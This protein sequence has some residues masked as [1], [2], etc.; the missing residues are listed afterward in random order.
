V[1]SDRGQ[2]LGTRE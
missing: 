1:D 2:E